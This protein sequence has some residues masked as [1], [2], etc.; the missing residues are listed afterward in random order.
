MLRC[1][2]GPLG[3]LVLYTQQSVCSDR[4]GARVWPCKVG[5]SLPGS[6]SFLTFIWTE[7][8]RT[9]LSLFGGG[10]QKASS[11]GIIQ[12]HGVGR[13]KG[14]FCSQSWCLCPDVTSGVSLPISGLQQNQEDLWHWVTV[15]VGPFVFLR[16][17]VTQ[18]IFLLSSYSYLVSALRGKPIRAG[19]GMELTSPISQKFENQRDKI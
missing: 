12:S 6:F 15:V 4:Q 7:G 9:G 14:A 18:G 8:L 16:R 1:Y 13:C 3:L 19:T 10:T 17:E 5:F 11:F 2:F